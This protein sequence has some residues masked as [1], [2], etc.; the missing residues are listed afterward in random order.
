MIDAS[1]VSGRIAALNFSR[2][3]AVLSTEI[4]GLEPRPLEFAHCIRTALCSV[5]WVMMCLPLALLK[6]A[7]PL[8]ARLFPSV[9]PEVR[10]ISFGSARSD[11]ATCARACSTLPPPSSQSVRPA[12][13]VAEVLRQERNHLLGDARIDRRSGRIV[14]I[15]RQ[16]HAATFSSLGFCVDLSVCLKSLMTDTGLPLWWATRSARLTD[17]R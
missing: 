13:R 16:P 6:F 17:E 15:D 9:A 4:G 2:D 3:D 14:E 11:S 1:T 7:A 10:T 5:F 12:G 8:I